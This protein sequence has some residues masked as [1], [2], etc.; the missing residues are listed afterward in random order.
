MIGRSTVTLAV[1]DVA[2]S[3]KFFVETLG[4]KP[5]PRGDGWAEVAGPEVT[6]TLHRAVGTE[7]MPGAR[8]AVG[9]ALE[10][11]EP[12]AEVVAVLENRGVRFVVPMARG[13]AVFVDPDGNEIELREP[14]LG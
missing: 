11:E 8:G 3:A 10:V 1:A 12:L 6:L 14:A 4:F 13:R 9:L 7:G 2:R 5:G